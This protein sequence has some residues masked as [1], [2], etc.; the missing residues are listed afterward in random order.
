MGSQRV[1]FEELRP[2][3]KSACAIVCAGAA[4]CAA[5]GVQT[6]C[7]H[8]NVTGNTLIESH[9]VWQGVKAAERP[10]RTIG[11]AA[12]VMAILA[13][14]LL[15][16]RVETDPQRLWVGPTSQAAQEKAAYEVFPFFLLQYLC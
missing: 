13:L 3:V 7:L 14:G 9:V 8:F 5:L 11:V 15:R 16:F 12:V 10:W 1:L 4:D 2:H 6:T